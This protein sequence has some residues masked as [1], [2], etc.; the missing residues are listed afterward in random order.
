MAISTT[1]TLAVA[2]CKIATYKAV[3]GCGYGCI[4]RASG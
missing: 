3:F 4:L 2:S 1:C